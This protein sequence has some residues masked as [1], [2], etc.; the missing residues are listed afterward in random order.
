MSALTSQ[1]LAAVGAVMSDAGVILAGPLISQLIAG[2]RSNLTFRLDDGSSSWVMRMPP[3]T[4]RTPSAHDVAREFRV[5]RA[6]AGTEVPVPPPVVLFEDDSVIGGP[7]AISEF[8][9]GRTIQTRADL[10]GL[11]DETVGKL[12]HELVGTLAALHRLDHVALGLERFGRPDG[13]AARQISRWRGQWNIVATGDDRSASAATEL[14][15][16]LAAAVPEQRAVGIVH[17]DYRIDNTI[18]R[19]GQEQV[20]I[21]AVV[22]WELST[23]GDPVADVA[24]MA[25]YR[26]PALD[27]IIGGP[28][29]WAGD[30]LPDANGLADMYER[31]G[32]VPLH[33]FK[34]HLALAHFKMAVIAAGIDHRHRLGATSGAGFDTAG[35][36]VLPLLEEGLRLLGRRQLPL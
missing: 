10:A 24:L 27:L 5:T 22:D 19:L 33:A 36:A 13:Y 26:H 23:I 31:A 14:G 17:G 1:E 29:A 9:S 30:R 7:F 3:R 11:S 21:A 18:V 2:G 34:F 12:V 8:V 6:I 28:T 20:E 25:A 4:G 32:G 35:Q 16:R 15:E